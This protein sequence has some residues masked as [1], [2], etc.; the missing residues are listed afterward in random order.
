MSAFETRIDF[1]QI[2]D[3]DEAKSRVARTIMENVRHRF[4]NGIAMMVIEMVKN[5]YDHAGGRGYCFIEQTDEKIFIELK[6]FGKDC[7]DFALLRDSPSSKRGN[8]INMGIGLR[9]IEKFAARLNANLEVDTSS[10]FH[11]K[12][13]IMTEQ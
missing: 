3:R 12:C 7:H 10:G 8:K 2:Q 6:D 4:P 1:E 5:I 13:T 11:Y 9:M